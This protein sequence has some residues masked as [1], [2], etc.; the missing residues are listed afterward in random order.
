M[1][2]L[3]K[4]QRKV[5][6]DNILNYLFCRLFLQPLIVCE[7]GSALF[8]NPRFE[9]REDDVSQSATSTSSSSKAQ[10][11]EETSDTDTRLHNTSSTGVEGVAT[12]V[13]HYGPPPRGEQ[14]EKLKQ[15]AAN[16]ELGILA[17]LK[18]QPDDP[19]TTIRFS[20]WDMAGQT[21]FYDM[22]HLLLTRSVNNLNNHRLALS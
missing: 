7:S 17:D 8:N 10:G 16:A 12:V 9:S 4:K 22:L 5:R 18:Q 11:A 20:I 1:T 21:V 15:L 14:D 3:T 2:R 13:K 19:S 6:Q